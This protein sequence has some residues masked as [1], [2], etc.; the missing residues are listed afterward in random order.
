MSNR[1]LVIPLII[2]IIISLQAWILELV[3]AILQFKKSPSL[4]PINF[5]FEDACPDDPNASSGGDD[6]CIGCFVTGPMSMQTSSIA[7]LNNEIET[8]QDDLVTKIDKGNTEILASEVNTTSTTDYTEVALKVSENDGFVS[9]LVLVEFIVKDVGRP[10]A[11]TIALAQNS[12]LPQKAK[13]K[14][15]QAG[16]PA[17]LENYLW[18]QQNGISKREQK[19][20]EIAFLKSKKRYIFNRLVKEILADSS[21]AK[22]DSLIELMDAQTEINIRKQTVRLLSALGRKSEALQKISELRQ[23]IVNLDNMEQLDDL[24]Q[25]E[26]ISINAKDLEENEKANF[27]QSNRDL[28]LS[29]YNK[30]DKASVKAYRMLKQMG[31]ELAMPLDVKI[32]FPKVDNNRTTTTSL[33]PSGELKGALS[34]WLSLYPNPVKGKLTVEYLLAEDANTEMRIYDINGKL[35][36]QQKLNTTMGIKSVDVSKL[37]SGVYILKLD[38]NSKEFVVK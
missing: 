33:P 14:I 29:I 13:G 32:A 2:T 17:D 22:A 3:I 16:L 10:V 5:T 19:E 1:I 34:S 4:A 11:K 18:A 12:P 6:P 31:E 8:K 7:L 27:Y 35:L 21:L 24:L 25:V 23:D 38:D 36:I 20:S 30:K 9:D 28:L 15:P 37:T 26:A